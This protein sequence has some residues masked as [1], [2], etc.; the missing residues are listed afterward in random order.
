MKKLLSLIAVISLYGYTVTYNGITQMKLDTEGNLYVYGDVNATYINTSQVNLEVQSRSVM[1]GDDNETI[2][3][4]VTISDKLPE[5]LNITLK[6]YGLSANEGSDYKDCNQTLVIPAGETYKQVSYTLIGDDTAENTEG[7]IIEPY[8]T[9]VEDE[10]YIRR[11]YSG[12]EQIDDNDTSS[13]D[14]SDDGGGGWF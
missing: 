8:I 7:F 6:C 11:L 9:K 13:S 4:N 2:D 12:K 1:E 14:S 10:K 3:F 5:D